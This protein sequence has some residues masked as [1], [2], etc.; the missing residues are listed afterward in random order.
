[1]LEREWNELAQ[2]FTCDERVIPSSRFFT[3]KKQCINILPNIKWI[4]VVHCLS[5]GVPTRPYFVPNKRYLVFCDI[6]DY[7]YI[8][9][10]GSGHFMDPFAY[11]WS[12]TNDI[13]VIML[14]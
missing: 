4:C 9:R 3:Y 11:I 2:Y 10:Y 7:V 5:S 8:D 6:N 1:M 12:H 14:D 13:S